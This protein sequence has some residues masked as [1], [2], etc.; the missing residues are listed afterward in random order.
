MMPQ[1]EVDMAGQKYEVSVA[2]RVFLIG[3][4]K[5]EAHVRTIAEYVDHRMQEIAGKVKTADSARLAIMMALTLAEELL[6]T[7]GQ[8]KGLSNGSV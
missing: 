8:R 3:S 1:K 4:E 6:E 2:G 5:G 7:S